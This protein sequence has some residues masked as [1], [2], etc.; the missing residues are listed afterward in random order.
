[1]ADIRAFKG[2]RYTEK[3]GGIAELVCPPYDIIS[4]AE[5]EAFVARN[6]RNVIRLELPADTSGG[7]KYAEAGK[8]LQSWLDEEILAA[9][10]NEG[11]YVYELAFRE[12]VETGELKTLR[13]LV[14]LVRLE[15]FSSGVVLPHEETL[16]K[17]KDD[18]L[19]LL[20][21]TNS[22]FS[23]IYSL[24]QD[25]A[26]I[27]RQ[28]LDNLAKITEPRYDFDDGLVRH[29]LWVA[30]DPVFI[31]A[32]HDDFVDRRL[33]IA[34]GHHRY[35]T[36][37]NYRRYCA[38][39]NLYNP[40]AGYVMMFLAD[41]ADDGLVVFP[42]HRL[43]RD[44][45]GF[46]SS[47]LLS[48]CEEFFDVEEIPP[49]ESAESMS[50]ALK[51]DNSK[52]LAFYSREKCALLTLKDGKSMAEILPEMSAAYQ[53]LD[54]SILHS[55]ILERLLGIDKENMANQRNLRYTRS[56]DEA[57]ASVNSGESNAAFFL[58]PTA[59][60]EIGEVAA[61]GEK[62][63]QKSTYFYP[64]LITGLVMNKLDNTD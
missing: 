63:P 60:S 49:F 43:I 39:N 54:V 15:E 51:S 32:V 47:V 3:A 33:Y 38:E 2:M 1:M 58:N 56:F 19:N 31:E 27:T 13:G 14:C 50:E 10:M 46:D 53:M 25:A 52:M 18:R 44:M 35:E 17:A 55:L 11:L 23:Q 45:E 22:N 8:I 28:R 16:S 59:V 48:A 21:A 4:E 6:E 64:K 5:R 9:D 62:M 36:A 34:D 26:H 42:T 57:V 61:C 40:G 37:L 20:K 24:Y 7:D 29:R 41:M 30:N 12:N